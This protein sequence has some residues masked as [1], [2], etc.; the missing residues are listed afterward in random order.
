VTALRT[1][2]TQQDL[3]AEAGDLTAQVEILRG[4][5]SLYEAS[6]ICTD[7]DCATRD[8]VALVL[9]ITKPKETTR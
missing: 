5:L 8:R 7:D 1:R 9:E 6:H 3:A 4:A 2:K